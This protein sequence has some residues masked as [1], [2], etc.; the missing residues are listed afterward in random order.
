MPSKATGALNGR[1]RYFSINIKPIDLRPICA[2]RDP[3]E[4]ARKLDIPCLSARVV[5]AGDRASI[6]S[7]KFVSR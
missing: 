4:T 5:V 1:S 6:E 2:E 7:M 3:N